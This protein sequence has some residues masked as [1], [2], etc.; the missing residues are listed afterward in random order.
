LSDDF[1]PELR[2]MLDNEW[3]VIADACALFAGW[4]PLGEF[5]GGSTV[6]PNTVRQYKRIRNGEIE[7]PSEKDFAEMRMFQDKWIES[8]FDIPLREPH[9]LHDVGVSHE[10]SVIDA[11]KVGLGWN[12][13]RIDNLYDAAVQASIIPRAF[14]FIRRDHHHVTVGVTGVTA[15]GEVGEI[16]KPKFQFYLKEIKQ[17]KPTAKLLYRFLKE[18]RDE[19]NPKPSAHDFIM[20]VHVTKPTEPLITIL[21]AGGKGIKYFDDSD[22]VLFYKYSTMATAIAD[23]TTEK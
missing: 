7:V 10:C 14:G 6:G 8:N 2:N 19:G 18:E 23:L 22:D 21:A 5:D 20:W 4:C 17:K 12:D 11:F 16:P 1:F 3:I 13:E 15:T 9:V